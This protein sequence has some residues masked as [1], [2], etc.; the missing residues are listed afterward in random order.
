[1]EQQRPDLFVAA[2]Q[3]P[4]P[5]EH[6]EDEEPEREDVAARIDGAA[7]EPFGRR[8]RDGRR[9]RSGHEPREHRARRRLELDPHRPGGEGAVDD[10]ALVSVRERVGQ[11]ARDVERR[12]GSE[13]APLAEHTVQGLGVDEGF[14]E[15]VAL[16]LLAEVEDRHDVLVPESER[17]P[18]GVLDARELPGIVGQR[19]GQDRDGQDGVDERMPDLVRRPRRAVAELLQHLVLAR[20]PCQLAPPLVLLHCIKHGR[21]FGEYGQEAH[22]VG[23]ARAVVADD[24]DALA[25]HS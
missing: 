18:D 15:V 5:F 13:R 16:R 8:V 24:E 21:V 9:R 12:G 19:R 4:L 1:M 17:L 22:D 3:E 25:F 7:R 2:G 14:D 6:L 23:L 20:E 11:L 10:A